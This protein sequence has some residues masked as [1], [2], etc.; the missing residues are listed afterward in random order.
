MEG[1]HSSIALLNALGAQAC[2]SPVTLGAL[3]QESAHLCFK[4]PLLKLSLPF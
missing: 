2:N 3:S 1:A 4:D